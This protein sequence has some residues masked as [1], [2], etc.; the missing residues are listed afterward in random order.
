MCVD[1]QDL[2]S[3]CLSIV[4]DDR[5]T[6]EGILRHRW[7]QQ[8]CSSA[9][10]RQTNKSQCLKQRESPLQSTA[11]TVVAHSRP[12]SPVDTCDDCNTALSISTPTVLPAHCLIDTTESLS[13]DRCVELC[14]ES[15]DRCDK[16]CA[17]SSSD[18]CVEFCVESS[19]DRCVDRE[20]VPADTVDTEAV[21]AETAKL[22]MKSS[23]CNMLNDLETRQVC[24]LCGGVDVVCSS[25]LCTNCVKPS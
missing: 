24:S 9:D 21:L 11:D 7:M 25:H 2:I 14:A 5:P 3:Q 16:P 17:E 4:P 15:S 18:R 13:S 19:L 22:Y 20:R 1:V 10:S 8:S 23:K 12:L 6:L